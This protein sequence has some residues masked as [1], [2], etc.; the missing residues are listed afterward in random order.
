VLASGRIVAQG[1]A[2]TLAADERV[3]NACLGVAA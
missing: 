3:K 1:V 2:R